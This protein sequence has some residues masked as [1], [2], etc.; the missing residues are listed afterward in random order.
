[1]RGSREQSKDERER[2]NLSESMIEDERRSREACDLVESLG[3]VRWTLDDQGKGEKS[4]C[5]FKYQKDNLVILAYLG[6]SF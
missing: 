4:L 3:S 2:T 1:M 6:S 5:P